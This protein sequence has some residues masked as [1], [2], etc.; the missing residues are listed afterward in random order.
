MAGE[1]PGEHTGHSIWIRSL[2]T[3]AVTA[4][5]GWRGVTPFVPVA[6]RQHM[7][8]ALT[9]TIS[10]LAE[11]VGALRSGSRSRPVS[12]N[13]RTDSKLSVREGVAIHLFVRFFKNATISLSEPFKHD[14]QHD[15]N[16]IG[17]PIFFKVR[18]LPPL[19]LA[20]VRK[21]FEELLKEDICRPSNSCWSSSLHMVLKSNSERSR[22]G[23]YGGF[24]TNIP[25]THPRF[26]ALYRKQQYFLDLRHSQGITNP[27]SS[28]R[29]SKNGNMPPTLFE[30]ST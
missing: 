9:V 16:T 23:E 15:T 17:S 25:S 22:C 19:K 11:A 3:V 26:C 5:H 2:N 12:Q 20:V 7:V 27:C 29:H 4:T 1:A 13:G 14:V 8:A 6:Q 30:S 28:R 10:E 21:E 24:R 18:P